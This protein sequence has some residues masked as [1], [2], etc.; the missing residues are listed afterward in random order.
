MS[1]LDFSYRMAEYDAAF[2]A[3][4]E[5]SQSGRLKRLAALGRAMREQVRRDEVLLQ[6]YAARH[7]PPRRR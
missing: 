1:R 4:F 3:Y 7:G 5:E 2:V 6:E